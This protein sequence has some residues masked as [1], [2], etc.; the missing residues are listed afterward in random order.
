MPISRTDKERLNKAKGLCNEAKVLCNI[1][2]CNIFCIQYNLNDW[3]PT[4]HIAHES[5][6]IEKSLALLFR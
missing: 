4:E 6:K 2:R 5:D 3:C 1:T